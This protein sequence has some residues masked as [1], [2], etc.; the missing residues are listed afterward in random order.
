MFNRSTKKN[1]YQNIKNFG[2]NSIGTHLAAL[3]IGTNNVVKGDI[4]NEKFLKLNYHLP[5][6]LVFIV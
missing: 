4:L 1:S 2:S 5:E 3:K 6:G